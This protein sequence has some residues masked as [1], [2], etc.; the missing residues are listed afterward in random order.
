MPWI[1]I[2]ANGEELDRR[3]LVAPVV[4][5]RSPECD[6]PVRDILLSRT[7][8]RIEP[9]GDGWKV[10]DLDSKNGTR[11]GWQGIKTHALRDGDHLRMGRTRILFH[12][13]LFEPAAERRPPRTD[14]VVRPADPH[15]ALSGT[16][17]DFILVEEEEHDEHGDDDANA[18][19]PQPRAFD[20]A[21]QHGGSTP[22]SQEDVASSFWC[23]GGEGAE[24]PSP[25]AAAPAPQV[26]VV[27]R[28]LPRI[29]PV[30][31]EIR[32]A[33]ETDLSLQVD[34]MP[35]VKTQA[36]APVVSPRRRRLAIAGLVLGGVAATAVAMMSIWLL[37]LAN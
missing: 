8:C 34:S 37:T 35:A 22:L 7:H 2:Y 16:V 10:T 30:Y 4:I 31:R 18:P 3:D 24:E 12:A 36:V 28:A 32:R 11:L 20:P 13:G 6:I 17:T 1:I 21:A 9:G 27:A 25:E 15:E 14:R 26:R 29:K 19:F 33:P 23:R 5:G